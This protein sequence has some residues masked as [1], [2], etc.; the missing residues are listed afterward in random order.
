MSAIRKDQLGPVG[1]HARARQWKQETSSSAIRP[2]DIGPIGRVAGA[3][4]IHGL[5]FICEVLKQG[6]M[7]TIGGSKDL[8]EAYN[9][10]DSWLTNDGWTLP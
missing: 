8:N 9:L 7:Q 4:T 10:V 2:S 5:T 3:R 6:K 1:P